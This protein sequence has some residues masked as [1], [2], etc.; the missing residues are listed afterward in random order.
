[1]IAWDAGNWVIN[2]PKVIRKGSLEMAQFLIGWQSR[3]AQN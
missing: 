1:M 2:N 3:N